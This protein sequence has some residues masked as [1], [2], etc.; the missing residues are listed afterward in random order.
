MQ[1]LIHVILAFCLTS[2]A[3]SQDKLAMVEL[4]DLYGK[5]I[6]TALIQTVTVDFKNITLEKALSTLANQNNLRLNYNREKLPLN[7]TV[8]LQ[9]SNVYLIEALMSILETT[10]TKLY[11]SPEGQLVLEGGGS[12]K[13]SDNKS[14]SRISG[15][16][17]GL[18]LDAATGEPLPGANVLIK[19]TSIG[20][21]SNMDGKFTILKINPGNYIIVVR[22]IGYKDVD[23]PVN[24]KPGETIT[25]NIE[26]EYAAI[27]GE[28]VEITAQAEGQIEAINQQ[29][30]A[31]TIKNVV[32]ADKIQ[33]IPDVNAA[34]SVAR[35]PGIS[36]IRSGGEGTK[37]SIRGMEPK[38]NVMMVN[39]VRM[40]STSG[41]DR[42]VDLNM[43]S[44]NLLTGIEVTK[45]ATA[46]MD[47]DA[48][49]GTVNLRIGKAK[50]GF[51]SNFTMQGGYGSVAD[52]YGN[53]K[54]TANL[55]NRFFND[56]LGIQIAA[57]A[58]EYD[59]SADA[60]SASYEINEEETKIQG[61][62]IIDLSSVTIT[63]TK[64]TRWRK[65]GGI[66]L[67]YHLPNGN[68][69]LNNFYS[70]LSGES[71]SM[72]NS[73][74]LQGSQFTSY[75]TASDASDGGGT[76][77]YSNALQGEFDLLGMK[78][79]FSI[80]NS[81]SDM[82]NP[83]SLQMKVIAEQDQAG[84]ETS[85]IEKAVEATPSEFLNSITMYDGKLRTKDLQSSA[86]D[87]IN[88]ERNAV[89]NFNIPYRFSNFI[90]GDLKFGGKY[91]YQK[92]EN[93]VTVNY[94]H[95][96]RHKPSQVFTQMMMDSLWTELGLMLDDT[97]NGIRAS[98]FE[99]PYY[100]V[101]NFLSGKEGVDKFFY[102]G[103]IEQ[104]E[105]YEA[106]AIQYNH[107]FLRPQES[108][109][110]DYKYRAHLSAFYFMTEMNLG[111]HIMFMPGVRY[112]NFETN[113]WAW[114]TTYYG[115]EWY[116]YNNEEVTSNRQKEH[117]F[118]QM[119]LR[120]K[121]VDWFDIRLASTRTIIYPDYNAF[122]PYYY[123]DQ[124]SPSIDFGN[125]E[126]KPALVQNYDI[127]TSLYDNHIGLFTCGYF[128]KEI[129][130][131]IASFSFKTKD[132]AKMYY[133]IDE[134]HPTKNTSVHTWINLDATTFV[135]GIELDWQTNF[136]YLP[137]ILRG[138]V[139]SINYTHQKSETQFP[140][141]TMK[142]E[143]TGI[144][145]KSV[146]VDSSR[147]VRMPYQ[148]N[149]IL[150]TT[151]GYDYRGFSARLSFLFQGNMLGSPNI[152]EELESY[153][154]DFFKWDLNVVQKLPWN[155]LSLYCNVM[156]INN[157]PDRRYVSK[158][159]LLSYAGY[160]GRTADIGIRYRF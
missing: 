125:I 118:P 34:E 9:L 110:N 120:F 17:T 132:L 74:A 139:F 60:L 112:E 21:A 144:W 96:D 148:A 104:M 82:Y 77:V 72:T 93:D 84:F 40:Q 94:I 152:R 47:A 153:T 105:H 13:P 91:R 88:I 49:G 100:D 137:S 117:W 107:F 22:Y 75:T 124:G 126:L 151:L 89:I 62:S 87:I 115:P 68:L 11:F 157:E 140:Y 24:L 154:D 43:I 42:S 38:Y 149:D 70:K 29:L 121:P 133:R 114:E 30:A 59:R 108:N 73:L 66:I 63:D 57:S 99:D 12:S 35:L 98:L 113:Y 55:S 39:G 23:I 18:I 4:K 32:A 67:D 150:N 101:G 90:T 116:D 26:L 76:K 111:K 135:R 103:S 83:G 54:M 5:K 128:Y 160:F 69:V 122:S 64:T 48:V 45:A 109:Q 86:S 143:G 25:K 147:T 97:G 146:F 71:I 81:V 33:E 8:T 52:T 127:Y 131:L 159:E 138:L 156:N 20:A 145:A 51:H 92:R 16:I 2:F 61:L 58:D 130:D 142:K 80:S 31:R 46:D 158:L 119:H 123:Y 27:K 136:W 15:K 14:N 53:Y 44:S 36:I 78:M 65:G 19:G 85:L 3:F 102:T 134:I 37:V 56:K 141:Q 79:D 28:M 10:G 41:S 6:P 106:L 1:K 155:G 129:D 7:E 50:P 95:P